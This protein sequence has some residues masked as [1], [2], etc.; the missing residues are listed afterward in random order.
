VSPLDRLRLPLVVLL[1]LVVQTTLLVDLRIRGAHPEALLVVALA[2]GIAGG[3]ERGAVVGFLS[4]L[5]AD[6]FLQTPFGLSALTYSLVGFAVGSLQSSVI[7]AAWWIPPLT[8][9]V[10][11]AAGVWLF[12]LLGLLV[13]QTQLLRHHVVV[14]AAVVA[15]TN[16]V[17]GLGVLRLVAWAMVRRGPRRAY[18]R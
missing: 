17:L 1:V 15:A 18:A 9:L 5:V 4:G 14:V 11:S 7:R 6:V 12:V 10:G 3:P 8:I 2:A 13:G 16:A